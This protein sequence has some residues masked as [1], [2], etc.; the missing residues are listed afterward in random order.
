MEI[1]FNICI[2]QISWELLIDRKAIE[3]QVINIADD[4]SINA[5]SNAIKSMFII[6]VR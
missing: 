6:I 2:R 3:L 1:H 5:V 4:E